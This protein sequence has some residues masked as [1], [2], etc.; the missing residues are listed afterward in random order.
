MLQLRNGTSKRLFYQDNNNAGN[1]GRPSP[2]PVPA[3]TTTTVATPSF[4]FPFFAFLCW[5]GWWCKRST[6]VDKRDMVMNKLRNL[7]RLLDDDL[8]I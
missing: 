4:K 3:T 6:N 8:P 2:S 7:Q 1:K 5:S